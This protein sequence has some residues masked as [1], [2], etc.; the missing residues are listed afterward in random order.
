MD[1][2]P[3]LTI[4]RDINDDYDYKFDFKSKTNGSSS[5]DWLVTGDTIASYIITV[6]TGLT[7]YGDSL[8]DSNTSVTAWFKD[9]TINTEQTA[10]CK[11]TTVAGRVIERTVTFYTTN[12]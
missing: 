11:V 7:Y 6:Q 3:G 8:T 1:W 2:E 10:A 9:G 4:T 5:S 12:L